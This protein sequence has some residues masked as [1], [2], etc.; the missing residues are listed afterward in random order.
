MRTEIKVGRCF[1][2]Y[3]IW[4]NIFLIEDRHDSTTDIKNLNLSIETWFGLFMDSQFNKYLVYYATLYCITA[5]IV[6][7]TETMSYFVLDS[8]SYCNSG[9]DW[10]SNISRLSA[11]NKDAKVILNIG[12]CSSEEYFQEGRSK[13]KSHVAKRQTNQTRRTTLV[14]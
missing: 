1:F 3:L 14:I 4:A 12:V 11:I 5:A 9:F 13:I 10:R 8:L 2:C 7:W 6:L